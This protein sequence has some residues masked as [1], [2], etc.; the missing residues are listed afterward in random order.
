MMK[1]WNEWLKD[2]FK[3]EIGLLDENLPNILLVL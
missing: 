3:K 2:I 1:E